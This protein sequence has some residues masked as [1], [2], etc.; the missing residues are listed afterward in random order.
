MPAALEHFDKHRSTVLTRSGPAS[1]IDTGGPGRTAL[2]VHG[3]GSSSYLW[4]HVIAQLDDERRCVAI[5]LPLHGQTPAAAG[6]DLSLPGLARFLADCCDA[7]Q[8]TDIDLVAND[9]GGAVSQ[10]LAA[11]HPELLH[12]LTLTNCETLDNFPPRVL[13]PAIWMARLGLLAPLGRW[14]ARDLRRARKRMLDTGY[15]DPASLPDEVARA[16]IEPVLGSSESARTYQR[17]FRSL[18]ARDLRAAG[19]G[20]ARLTAP[21]VIVWGTGDTIFPVKWAYRLRDTIASATEVVEVDGGRLFFPDERAEELTAALRR[22][23][24]GH[25]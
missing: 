15:Q 12:T 18:H 25:P 22:H 20:L 17:L 19:P 14:L 2:F 23:W 8:L 1:Y 13:L 10:V 11:G 6:Q 21:A 7:L 9:T 5:D 3:V 24:S 4:R 16:W